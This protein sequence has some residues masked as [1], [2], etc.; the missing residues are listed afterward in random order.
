MSGRPVQ[1]LD[2]CAGLSAMSLAFRG[3]AT[4]VAFSEIEP[5][6][7]A[8]LER[9]HPGVPNLGDMNGFEAWPAELLARAD[10]LAG[11]TPCQAFSVAGARRSLADERGNLTLTYVRLANH[12]DEIRHAAG[13]PAAV[14]LWENVPGVL[15]TPDN[16]F[17]CF[18]GGLAGADGAL[19][20]PGGG[21]WGD[22]GY[23]RGPRRTIAWRVLNAQYFGLAQRRERVFLVAGA[24]AAGF[25]PEKVLFE[26]EGVRR[27]SAPGRAAGKGIAADLA[28]CLRKSDAGVERDGLDPVVVDTVG[29]LVE[30]DTA[31]ALRARAEHSYQ[32]VRT[33]ALEVRRLT[34]RECE[35]LQGCPD[36]HTLLPARPADGPR[37]AALGNSMAVPVVRWIVRRLAAEMGWGT[38]NMELP[39]LNAA[40]APPP[41]VEHPFPA[42]EIITAMR[43]GMT[44]AQAVRW[45]AEQPRPEQEGVPA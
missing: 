19:R 22:A 42:D 5:F 18:L 27:D 14:C 13:R 44:Y 6:C 1:F 7:A 41:P 8:L 9:N 32:F 15:N 3:I 38:L 16:A 40:P 29:P 12:L 10:V 45:L 4:P 17:G 39:T 21:R 36:D 11:G 31:Q 33:A 23:V 34:P 37:Y 26:F 20:P 35:R 24:G 2:V 28:P 30:N 25:C 43:R